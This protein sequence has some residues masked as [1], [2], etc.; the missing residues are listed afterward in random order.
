M[1]ESAVSIKF[2][3]RVTDSSSYDLFKRD[4]RIK[5]EK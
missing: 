2:E 3:G 5:L 1:G 4:A